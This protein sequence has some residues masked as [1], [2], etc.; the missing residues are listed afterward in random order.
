MEQK[1][2][3]NPTFN[4]LLV[5]SKI[6]D[7]KAESLETLTEER[8]WRNLSDMEKI[9]EI[10]NF[11]KDEI[12]FGYNSSDDISASQVLKDGYGQCNTKANLF[13]ALLRG[14]GIPNRIH[15][16][17]IH[18][19]LQKGA[20][21][22][23]WYKMSPAFILHSWVEVLFQNEWYNLEGLILDQK[24]LNAL[25]N[26]F[27]DCKE[28]FCGY[29]AY[30]DQFQSPQI[31]WNMNDTYIQKKGIHHDFGLYNTPDEFYKSHQQEL[32]VIKRWIYRYFIRHLM[33]NN[34]DKIRKG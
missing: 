19:A 17:T 31:E 32:G 8:G 26:K 21:T 6:L 16:F 15:G 5:A 1:L 24:Y 14:V 12:A 29:G 33:N 7:F 4:H 25:Q 18:K 11:V 3:L 28:T 2:D 9:K 23:I 34:V 20:I 27:Q 22:G 10:Y 13:M 30:T